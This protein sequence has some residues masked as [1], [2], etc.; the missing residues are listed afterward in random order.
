MLEVGGRCAPESYSSLMFS[1]P[2]SRGA[3]ECTGCQS[4]LVI[5][6]GSRIELLNVQ[7]ANP[8]GNLVAEEANGFSWQECCIPSA[9]FLLVGRRSNSTVSTLCHMHVASIFMCTWFCFQSMSAPLLE[10]WKCV[11]FAFRW[12]CTSGLTLLRAVWLLR[13]CAQPVTANFPPATSDFRR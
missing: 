1:L 4:D 6:P 10:L 12:S 13:S 5:S 9:A 7:S 8:T 2:G 3:V 11:D